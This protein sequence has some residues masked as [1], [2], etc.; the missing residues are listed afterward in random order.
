MTSLI[1]FALGYIAGFGTASQANAQVY[2][3]AS[4]GSTDVIARIMAE[5]MRAALGQALILEKT[6]GAGGYGVVRA[7]RAGPDIRQK[8]IDFSQHIFPR[9]QQM[10]QALAAL[11]KGGNRE[12]VADRQSRR[13]QG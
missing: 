12:V 5:G 13:R 10:S 6:S 3:S 9:A 8:L 11:S 1:L 2:P 7:I 4:G